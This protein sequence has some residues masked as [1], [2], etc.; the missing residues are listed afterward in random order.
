MLLLNIN[1]LM[2]MALFI[3]HQELFHHNF[4]FNSLSKMLKFFFVNNVRVSN[5]MVLFS[6][7]NSHYF[8]KDL[9]LEYRIVSKLYFWM[10]ECTVMLVIQGMWLILQNFVLLK[11]NTVPSTKIES[12]LSAFTVSSSETILA[13]NNHPNVNKLTQEVSVLSASQVSQSNRVSVLRILSSSTVL[14]LSTKVLKVSVLKA[15]SKIVS[16]TYRHQ[17]NVR[18]VFQDTQS[19]VKVSVCLL[20]RLRLRL[21]SSSCWMAFV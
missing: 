9:W 7:E 10:E 8:L 19:T 2:E 17:V 21:R 18:P 5:Q 15:T 4:L 3:E 12:V 20:V 11:S 14:L 16:S 1:S 6:W 13:S